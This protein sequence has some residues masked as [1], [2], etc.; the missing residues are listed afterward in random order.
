[1]KKQ[2]QKVKDGI[3]N[4]LP[5]TRKGKIIGIIFAVITPISLG[6]VAGVVFAKFFVAKK[7]DYS[8]LNASDLMINMDVVLQKYEDCVKSGTPIE[9][10][11]N[12][13]E[14]VN[15]AYYNYSNHENSRSFTIGSA[16]AAIVNQSIRGCTI[17]EGNN[18][19]EESIS[20]SNMVALATRMYQKEDGSVDLHRGEAVDEVTASWGDSHYEYTHDEFINDFGKTPSTSLIY[21]I[22]KKTMLSGTDSVQKTADGYSISMSLHPRKSVV[23]YVKQMKSISNLADYPAFDK[24]EISFNISNDLIIEK[25]H[26]NESYYALKEANLGADTSADVNVYYAVDGG[27]TIPSLS[28][29]ITYPSESEVA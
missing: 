2:L 5:K 20:K 16:N 17:R 13:Y 8:D 27:F 9:E 25:M 12:S 15:L 11:M 21:I 14:I 24:I 3:K 26:V 4:N 29:P 1:M 23:N 10:G 18:Y 22:S 6:V 7:A 28:E 19:L